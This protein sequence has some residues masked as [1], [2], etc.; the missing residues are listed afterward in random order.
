MLLVVVTK[1]SYLSFSLHS[2]IVA[3]RIKY[4]AE[5][6]SDQKEF[7]RRETF[8]HHGRT[9]QPVVARVQQSVN[10]SRVDQDAFI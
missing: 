5:Q 10:T 2:L 4:E 7:L 3:E 1:A 6:P 9:R 8:D